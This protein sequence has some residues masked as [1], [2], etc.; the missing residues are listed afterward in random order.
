MVQVNNKTNIG[1]LLAFHPETGQVF[2][3]FGVTV[4]G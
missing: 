3:K 1:E 2:R 4:T